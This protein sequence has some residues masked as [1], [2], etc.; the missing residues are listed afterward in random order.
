[1]LVFSSYVKNSGKMKVYFNFLGTPEKIKKNG[2]HDF[3]KYGGAQKIKVQS[4]P[5]Q[6]CTGYEVKGSGRGKGEGG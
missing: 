4:L 3:S 2:A 1:M 5:A 6:I